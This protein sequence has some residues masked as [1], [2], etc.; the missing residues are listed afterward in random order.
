MC[1]EHEGMGGHGRRLGLGGSGPSEQ[2]LE[3]AG[4]SGG[5]EEGGRRVVVVLID[6]TPPG[7]PGD[8]AIDA[9]PT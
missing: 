4:G 5:E 2:G 3:K 1:W 9:N 8:T 7:R 6:L